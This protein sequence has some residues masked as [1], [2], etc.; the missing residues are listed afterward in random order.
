M[1]DD[2]SNLFQMG[3]ADLEAL[4]RRD[5]ERRARE[6]METRA[7]IATATRAHSEK[8]AQGPIPEG[9]RA[10]EE[11]M[12]NA[13]QGE[14]I[15]VPPGVDIKDILVQRHATHGDFTDDATTAQA[16]KRVMHEAKNWEGLNPIKREALENIATKIA[17]ILSGNS[18]HADTWS[19]I[20][21]YARLVEERL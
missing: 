16:L 11:A 20:Q 5:G 12:R 9:L 1:S 15:P 17:R 2:A 3:P 6:A 8:Y 19:D 10:V 13:K 7:F 14:A 4:G 18:N 21:G